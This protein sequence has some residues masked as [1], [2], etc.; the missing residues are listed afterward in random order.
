MSRVLVLTNLDVGLYKFRKELLQELIQRGNTVYISLPSGEFIEP[1][2]KLG[3]IFLETAV[4]RRGINPLTDGKLMLQYRRLVKK[5]KPDLVIT[6]TI[7]PNIYGGIVCRMMHVP[8]A[9]NITGLGTAFQ[10]ENLIKKLV[11][12]LYRIACK[13]AKTVF[14]EN[15]ENHQIFLE[16]KLVRKEQTCCL[17]GAGVNI[18]EYSFSEYPGAAEP[19]HF[20]FIGRVMKEKGVDELFEAARRIKKE[21]PEAVFDIVGPYEEDY[22]DV[23]AQLVQEDVIQYHGFQADVK[24]Y[25]IKSHCFILPS[26]HEGMANTLLEAGAMG[27]PLITSAIHGCLE[28]VEDGM[29]GYLVKVK[30]VDDLCAKIESFI[31]IPWSEKKEMG[32]KSRIWIENGFDKKKVVQKTVEQLYKNK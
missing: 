31:R 10:K 27:R 13:K 2:Q 16:E 11:C 24:P 29:N 5:V 7:K 14:F 20:L 26:W 4:D 15:E 19:I 32:K 12:F 6:Y 17:H 23:I 8:Y 1:L 30:N 22:E 18:E 9:I 3:C 25:I 21:Y 28:A